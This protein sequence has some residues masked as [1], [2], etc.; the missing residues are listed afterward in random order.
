[1]ISMLTILTEKVDNQEQRD[2]VILREILRKNQ[3]CQRLKSKQ[4]KEPTAATMKSASEELMSTL[5]MAEGRFL[6]KL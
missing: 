2:N 4:T 6:A 5:D 1:M 3:K